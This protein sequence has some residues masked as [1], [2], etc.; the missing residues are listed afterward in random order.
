MA[1]VLIESEVARERIDAASAWLEARGRTEEVLVVAHAPAA[2]HALV[3]GTALRTG[4][5]FGWHRTTLARLAI[6]IASPVL[7]E[8]GLTPAAGLTLEALCA[9][10]VFAR[11][12]ARS[13]GRLQPI[14]QRPGLPRALARTLYELR[15]EGVSAG[16]IA[17]VSPELAELAGDYE[18]ELGRARLA[19][20]A[21]V[22]WT[23]ARAVPASGHPHASLP[24]LLLDVEV[25]SSAARA[26]VAALSARAPEVL[27]TVAQGDVRSRASLEA[28]LGASPERPG[29]ARPRAGSLGRLQEHLFGEPPAEEH[30]LGD[31]VEVLS[32]PGES[33]ECVEIV[34]RVHAAAAQGTP[35]DRIAILLRAPGVHR[36]HLVEAL[37]RGGVPATFASG[38]VRPDPSGRAFLALLGCAAEALS[39]TR[40]AEYL[41]LGEV[42][43]ADAS[44]AP[45]PAPAAGQRWVPPDEEAIAAL[46]E[47]ARAVLAPAPLEGADAEGVPATH[48]DPELPVSGGTLRAP[49]RWERLLVD[50]A[51]IGGRERWKGRLEGLGAELDADLA[52]LED[53]DDPNAVRLR[54]MREDLRHLS[55]WTLPL[56]DELGALPAKASWGE[57]I[58]ALGALATR[59]LRAPERVLSVLA[60]LTPMSTVGPVGLAEVRQVLGRRLAELV[61]SPPDSSEGRVLVAPVDAVRG[62]SFD[63]VFVPGLA[64]RIFP[65]KIVEDPLLA[66]AD[67]AKIARALPTQEDRA[68]AERLALRLAVG[69]AER[70]I[71]LS[72]PRID[73]ENARPRVPSFYVLEVVRAAEGRLAGFEEV[74]RRAGEAS[75]TRLAWPAPGRPEDA[76]DDAEFDLALLGDLVDRDGTGDGRAHYLLGANQHLARALRF[77]ARRWLKSWKSADGLVDPGEAAKAALAAHALGARSYSPTAL[78][79]FAACPYRFLLYAVWKLG[80]RE[81]PE[82]IEEMDPLQKGSLVHEILYE[83]LVALRAED[84]LPVSPDRFEAASRHLER[85]VDVVAART[86]ERLCPAIPR[87]WDDE[88]AAVRADLRE[89]LRRLSA[90]PGGW[91]PW[92]FELSFGLKDRRPQDPA[93]RV[94]PVPLACGIQLRGSID[95]VERR[96][97]GVLRVTDYKTGK[98]RADKGAV[99]GGGETLQPVLYALVVEALFP[100]HHVE[101]GRLYYCTSVGGFEERRVPLDAAARDAAALVG[102]TIGQALDEAFLPAAPAK[103]ACKWCDYRPVCGP[104]EELR[105][106]RK[107]QGRLAGLKALRRMP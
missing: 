67:R 29:T 26:F 54:R 28:A 19:D 50:A 16:A 86:R 5:A 14:G 41:S 52:D 81:V 84:L 75:E 98:V 82:A 60:E 31:D 45:P 9:R 103:D 55:G 102:K 38:T 97:D 59:A 90:E 72:Y 106:G 6:E 73:L 1:R 27:A 2:A 107:P 89:M 15:L 48:L 12:R 25:S 23:A 91:V 30:S 83:L 105:T 79:T 24:L 76:I 101:E 92:R 68:Q 47:S 42:P 32:A 36:A 88:I 69:A 3:R 61:A 51:V 58:D 7:A 17:A 99:V 53:P 20:R 8:D 66:D 37:R 35:F 18:A 93:S 33:R 64:E 65:P 77:R 85:V 74:A 71:V 87:V 44:G 10:V 34:R 22:L 70:R 43:D 49:H 57:W 39:A 96:A 11:E 78:Q 63:L 104:Y 13:L 56:L 94:E 100:D 80:P 40:F 95:L 21:L 46:P 4:G 62:M